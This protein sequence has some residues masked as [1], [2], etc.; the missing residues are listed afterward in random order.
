MDI[1][2]AVMVITKLDARLP[3]VAPPGMVR[4]LAVL[5]LLPG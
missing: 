5:S 4:S 1:R 2:I 3:I